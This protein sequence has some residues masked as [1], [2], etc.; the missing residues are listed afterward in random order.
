MKSS[1]PN[2]CNTIGYNY[3]FKRSAK[4]KRTFA[5]FFNSIGYHCFLK[6]FASLKRT[7]SNIYD[8]IRECYTGNLSAL[9]ECAIS[10][11]RNWISAKFGRDPDLACSR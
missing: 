3:A 7:K 1:F 2:V 6:G 11:N 4:S 8:G 9:K 5:D 10:N